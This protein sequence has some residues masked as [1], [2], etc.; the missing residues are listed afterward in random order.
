MTNEERKAWLEDLQV[1][2]EVSYQIGSFSGGRTVIDTIKKITPT[3]RMDVGHMR[4]DSNGY[5]MGKSNSWTPRCVLNPVTDEIRNEVE[6][7][8]LVNELADVNFKT[9]SLNQLRA[10]QLILSTQE[11]RD[12]TIQQI[13]QHVNFS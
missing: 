8:K 13:E 7:A 4:F 6:R 9:L 10:I 2:D 5:E 12:E 3:R 11:L 1:G